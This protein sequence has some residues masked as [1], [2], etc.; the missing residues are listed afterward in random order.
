MDAE[1]GDD[2]GDDDLYGDLED[3][4]RSA[5]Y[6]KLIAKV[7]DLTK[8]NAAMTSE[9]IETRQQLKILV[10]EKAVVENN[11]ILLYNTAQREM[12]RKDKQIAQMMSDQRLGASTIN[13][14]VGKQHR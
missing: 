10:D 6:V 4:G 5:D 1:S 12:D 8:K 7:A 11:M 14:S 3:S 13:N 9:L 2:G